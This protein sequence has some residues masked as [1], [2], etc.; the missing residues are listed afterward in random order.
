MSTNISVIK[1]L[2]EKEYL[3]V[4][5]KNRFVNIPTILEQNQDDIFSL[6]ALLRL[7]FPGKNIIFWE[8]ISILC[9]KKFLPTYYNQL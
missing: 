9:N 2:L 1:T 3:L 4:S 7:I 8:L 6:Y 5:L